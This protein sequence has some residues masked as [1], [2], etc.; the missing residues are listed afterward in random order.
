M[1][2]KGPV[3]LYISCKRNSHRSEFRYSLV[4]SVKFAPVDEAIVFLLEKAAGP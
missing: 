4:N 3:R 1:N 2:N